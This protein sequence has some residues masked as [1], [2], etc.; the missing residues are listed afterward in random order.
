M[1][2][3]V[4]RDVSSPT[5]GAAVALLLVGSVPEHDG[6]AAEFPQPPGMGRVRGVDLLH[7]IV[8]VL[9]LRHDP[10]PRHNA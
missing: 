1:G 5:P 3:H 8:V 4:R 10:R 2:C 9:V 6:D 7:D